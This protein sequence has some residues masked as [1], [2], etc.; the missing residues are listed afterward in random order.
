MPDHEKCEIF[1]FENLEQSIFGIF[2][3]N[4]NNKSIIKILAI[5]FLL[6]A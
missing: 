4:L 5:S 1:T 2:A 3:D 6:I